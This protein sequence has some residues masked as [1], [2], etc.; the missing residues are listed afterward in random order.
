MDERRRLYLF[1]HDEGHGGQ[2]G[3]EDGDHDHDDAHRDAPVQAG[4]SRDPPAGDGKK[5]FRDI[6]AVSG[7]IQSDQDLL[8]LV[9]VQLLTCCPSW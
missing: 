9:P 4:E 1:E 8:N 5:T 6:L 2:R 7:R 3:E